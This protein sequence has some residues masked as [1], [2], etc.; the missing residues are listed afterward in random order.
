MRLLIFQIFKH[1]DGKRTQTREDHPHSYPSQ[2][3]KIRVDWIWVRVTSDISDV[4][5]GSLKPRTQ[6]LT[7]LD[8]KLLNYM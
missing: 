2:R 1:R 8:I 4:G 3:V 5:L 7:R 6:N